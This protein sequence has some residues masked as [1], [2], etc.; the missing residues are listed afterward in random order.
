M[1]R[2][3]LTLLSTASAVLLSAA[4]CS[5][6][7]GVER[8]RL[9]TGG[10]VELVAALQPVDD[11]GELLD[12]IQEAALERV[13]PYGFDGGL[14][15]TVGD[16]FAG[17]EIAGDARSSAPTASAAI[18]A[19]TTPTTAADVSGTNVQEE[20]ID[21]PDLVKAD[22]ERLLVVA[23]GELR[24]IDV[25][26]PEP[27]EAGS[28]VLPEGFA[29]QLLVAGD[30]A[31]VLSSG[32]GGGPMPLEGDVVADSGISAEPT[33]TAIAQVDVSAPDALAVIDTLE[34]E[35]SILDARMVGDTARVVVTSAPDQ[36]AFVYPSR[37][38]PEAEALA[39]ATNR[40]VIEGSAV[41]DW[42]P[43]Y[44]RITD[45]PGSDEAVVD[46]GPLVA[47]DA[48]ALPTEFSGFGTLSVLTFDVP[49]E[50]GTGDATGVLADGQHVYA[51]A[52]H[53]YVATTAYPE[54]P[55]ADP[56]QDFTPLPPAPETAIHRFATDSAGP[57][58]YEVSGRVRGRLL[59][60]F[61]MSE[62]AGPDGATLLRV[63]TTDDLTQESYV[64]VLGD[65]DGELGEIGQVGGLGEGEEIYSVRFLGDMGY[66]VTFRQTDPLYTVDL[67]DP[68]DPTVVGELE[69]LGYSAYLHPLG[70]DLL[71]GVGQDAT[72]SGRTT[73][74]QLSLFDVSDPARP[75]RLQ[76]VAI[77]GATSAAEYDHHAF[78]S[79][80]DTGLVVLP[81]QSY[82]GGCIGPTDEIVPCEDEFTLGPFTGAVGFHVTTDGID[83]V[84]RVVHDDG[85]VLARSVVVGDTLYTVSDTSLVASDLT[86]LAPQATLDLA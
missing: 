28:V 27:V 50:L 85:S 40:E 60:Q 80:P 68:A 29:Q 14:A 10:D 63:A 51:S 32:S 46:E 31:L 35:G 45:P 81:V 58:S 37:P 5:S 33:A 67:S 6:G 26:G 70:G 24:W 86:T 34:V 19:Q 83:E 41:E 39:E 65:G 13:G 47:C 48:M 20:G 73:G 22:A 77:P 74:T 17:A 53:L 56:E 7:D 23:G 61:S 1:R 36:L 25:T 9:D 30:R 42:L 55:E 49:D 84:G 15:F 44:R 62:A 3:L 11:C 75:E 78:L 2:P 69:L 4:A 18:P 43:S 79:W 21:E 72:A 64:T 71:L 54:A 82:G 12:A 76:Q 57:A 52:D 59:D 16:E 38:S 66:V 8:A